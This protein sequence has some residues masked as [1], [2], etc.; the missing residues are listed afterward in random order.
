MSFF[1]FAWDCLAYVLYYYTDGVDEDFID[2]RD[3]G[4]LVKMKLVVNY[5]FQ[6]SFHN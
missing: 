3:S 2:A 6:L 1:S 4:R 5:P